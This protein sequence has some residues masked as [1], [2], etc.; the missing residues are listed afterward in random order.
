MASDWPAEEIRLGALV[1]RRSERPLTPPLSAPDALP[2]GE[3]SPPVFERLVSE[4]MWLVDGMNDIRGYGRSGQDQGGL[5]LIGRKK[6]KT[7]VYQVRRIVSLSAPALRAA[8]TDFAGPPRTTTPEEKW[9][10]RRFDSVRFVLAAGCIVDDTPVEDE[11]VSL[12]ERYQGD[13]DI[14]LYD[15]RALS[16]AL[17]DRPSLV[18]GVF[19]PEWA[20]AFCGIEATPVSSLP[21]GYALL[22]DPLEHL[23]LAD[24][25]HRAQQLA[26]TEE[27]GPAA[28]LFGELAD[29]LEQASFTGHAAQLRTRQ[30]DLLAAAGQADTAFTV[31][32]QLLLDRYDS[33]DRMFVDERLERLASKAGGTAADI[34]SVLKALADWFEHG[35][36]LPPVTAALEAVVRASDPL[37]ARLVLAV[38]EQIVVDEHP[39]DHPA[40]LSDLVSQ[41]APAQK[42]LLRLRLECCLA[43]LAVRAGQGPE[44]SY[45][46]LNR[47]ALGGRLQERFAVLVHM[48]R[49]RALALADLGEEA[50]EAYRRAVLVAT[51]EGLGGDA[52]HALRA[53]SFLS[54]QY[55]LGLRESSQA[56]LSARTVGAKG[57]RL[58]ELSFSPAVSALEGLVDNNLPDAS[59][60]AHQWLWQDRLSGA[61][62]DENLAH[63]RYGEVFKRAGEVK[64]AVRQFVLAGRRKDACSAAEPASEFLDVSTLLQMRARWVRSAAAAVTGQQADLIPDDAVAGIAARLTDIVIT[65]S[66]SAEGDIRT[67]IQALGALAALDERLPEAS[68][69]QVLPLLVGWIPRE[70]TTSRF[71]DK[72][73][74]AFLGACIKADLPLAGQA[75]QALLDAWKLDMNGAD[76]LLADLHSHLSSVVPVVRERAQQGH[77]GAAALLAHWRVDDPSVAETARELADSV[78]AEPVGT[79]R[80]LYSVGTTARQCAAFLTVYSN[81]EVSVGT[82]EAAGILRE[83]VTAHLLLWAEDRTDTADRRS[84][85]VHALSIL[86]ETLPAAMR[87]TMFERIM[88]LYDDP[89]EHPSDAFDRRT[90]HP[91]SRHKINE[92]REG[93][94]PLEVLQA[95]A[96]LATTGAQAARVEQRLLP[97]LTRPAQV[98]G[99]SQLQA[100]AML[101]LDRLTPAPVSLMATHASESIRHSAVVCWGRADHRDPSLARVFAQDA[102]PGVRR[103]LAHSLADFSPDEQRKYEAITEQLR[104]DTSARVRQAAA[105]IP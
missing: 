28:E 38:I 23:D 97:L 1:S 81:D 72:Q 50:I 40:K 44:D 24:A 31:A 26:E 92:G 5:D 13:I 41:V 74:L 3:L 17:R 95:S 101:A 52:R 43:D 86:A 88:C 51:R 85:A 27:P 58:L 7:H 15:A 20:K 48:R 79:D 73:M 59:R 36:A 71:V 18:A 47:R 76:V 2:F 45:A 104:I 55:N 90:Q 35:Y 82:G 78:L 4:V 16:G 65:G 37:A 75:A 94:L 96:A 60:A 64:H 12:K 62:T 10:E 87:D 11:L 9:S 89:G 70:P 49:G 53:I 14:D 25:L 39:D 63:Q 77:R 29:A 102:N 68:G 46:D 67:V 54:D 66:Q 105:R 21:H 56:M 98:R 103:A 19:G 57:A 80:P 69:Q 30:R 91:L 42:G 8:V 93:R 6:G 33:G 84:D 100:Q 34:Y 61:L 32:V 99:N 83:R 22:N